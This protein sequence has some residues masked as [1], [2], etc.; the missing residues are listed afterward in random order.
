MDS[1]SFKKKKMQKTCSWMSVFILT[2]NQV[3]WQILC[4]I[5]GQ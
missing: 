5:P 3:H 1:P 4:T 2:E